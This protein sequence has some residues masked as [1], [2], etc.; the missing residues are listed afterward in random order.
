[1]KCGFYA[2]MDAEPVRDLPTVLQVDASLE[3]S[4]LSG[5][6]VASACRTPST[7]RPG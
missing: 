2:R 1:M 4:P 6:L 3:D 7:P 5:S